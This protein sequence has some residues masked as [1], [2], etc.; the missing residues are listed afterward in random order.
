MKNY[1]KA[2]YFYEQALKDNKESPV[3]HN[4]IGNQNLI[5]NYKKYL[6][7]NLLKLRS[8]SF[9]YL[10]SLLFDLNYSPDMTAKEIL[11]IINN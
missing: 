3:I 1:N 7:E 6:K 11:N 9:S 2:L 5:G 4:N 10:E 8:L